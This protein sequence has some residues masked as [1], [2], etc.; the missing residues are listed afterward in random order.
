MRV[1]MCDDEP[2]ALQSLR[3][4]LAGLDDVEIVATGSD[5]REAEILIRALKPDLVFLDV[6]MPELSGFEVVDQIHKRQNNTDPPLIVFV[7]A[8]RRFAPQAFD[9]GAIDF[10]SKPIR[11]ERLD[12]TIARARKALARQEAERR[13]GE[14][15]ATLEQSRRSAEPKHD[16]HV[17][18]PR[19]GG[20]IRIDLVR[21]NWVAAEGSYVRL[22]LDD[23]SYLHRHAIGLMEKVL[24]PEQFLRIHR[25]Y[26][27]R[28]D[29]VA[30]IRR[31][32]HGGGEVVLHSGIVLPLGR[33]YSTAARQRLFRFKAI[34]PLGEHGEECFS[35]A[36]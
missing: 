31:T 32:I 5:G 35:S 21:V 28:V 2:S 8:H 23:T 12:V 17:W 33:K 3:T 25:S 24:D 22:H 26:L 13:L 18:V 36:K 20:M 10:L 14:V 30:S 15:Q 7:T 34:T 6:E 1:I 4:M 29:C 9:V 11:R 19:R 16:A 27:V